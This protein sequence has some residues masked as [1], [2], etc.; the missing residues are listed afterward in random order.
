VTVVSALSLHISLERPPLDG[1]AKANGKTLLV[2]G[3]SSN[4]GG[5][6]VKYASDAGYAVI[7]TSSPANKMFVATR[8]PAYIFDHTETP[9]K[10]IA[11]LKAHGPYDAIFDAIG[12]PTATA[13]IG[14]L[15]AETGGVYYSTLPSGN[16][17][18][19]PQNVEKRFAIYGAK[20][21]E[22]AN[23]HIK[24]WYM[25]EY[26]PHGLNNGSIFPNTILK[27][28]G[29]L[30]SVQEALDRLFSGSASGVKIAINPQE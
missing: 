10:V 4:V 14:G 20:F 17:D 7:T 9:E 21:N 6:A 8:C 18:K 29:G 5:L 28:D 25:E 11:E 1:K 13:I 19:L 24:K 26:L 23:Q 12:T 22:P 16:D 3:G 27:L 30:S 2:Y 15:L